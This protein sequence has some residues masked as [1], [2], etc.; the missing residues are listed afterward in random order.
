MTTGA[1]SNE[2]EWDVVVASREAQRRREKS[3]AKSSGRRSDIEG[4]R[5]VAIALVVIFHVWVGKVSG[6]VDIFLALS[7][8]FFFTG[9]M[10]WPAKVP[11]PERAWKTLRRLVPPMA[12]AVGTGLLLAVISLPESQLTQFYKQAITS[13]TFTQNWYLVDHGDSY[14]SASASV[15][16][17]QHL[18][19]MSVQAQIFLGSILVFTVVAWAANKANLHV[20]RVVIAAM[21]LLT[22]ASMVWAIYRHETNQAVA[23]YDTFARFWEISLGGLFGVALLKRQMPK[24]TREILGVIG[25]LL[26]VLSAWL[27]N[28]AEAYPG[29]LALVPVGSAMLMTLAGNGEE[30][31]VVTRVLDS[32]LPR[33]IGSIAYSLYLW[34]WILL[35]LFIQVK[36][37]NGHEVTAQ[38]V[39]F[40]EGSLII[41]VSIAIA[42]FSSRGIEPLRDGFVKNIPAIAV[43]CI[44]MVAAVSLF[45]TQVAVT[46]E[47]TQQAKEV[48]NYPGGLAVANGWTAG[49]QFPKKS[50]APAI[51]AAINDLPQTSINGCLAEEPVTEVRDCEFGDKTAD[52]FAIIAGGSHIEQWLPAIS[53]L[54]KQQHFKLKVAV[55]AGCPLGEG[56]MPLKGNRHDPYPECEQW[57]KNVR[58]W[59]L[60]EKPEVLITNSTRPIEFNQPDTVSPE[61]V[62]IFRTITKAG[63]PIIGIRDTPWHTNAKAAPIEIPECLSTPGNNESDCAVPRNQALAPVD[64]AIAAYAGMPGVTLVDMSN[65]ICRPD[66]CNPIEGNIIVYRDSHH[67]TKTYV[68]S[69]KEELARQ[70]LQSPAFKSLAGV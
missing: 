12:L 9:L 68:M 10:T 29:L 17:F 63:I 45:N 53:A 25:V 19:S 2:L 27:I 22:V 14:A 57:Q 43:T 35:I 55:K 54:A 16:P 24:V 4:M 34:H 23:Y 11:A 49:V 30:R 20:R 42:H 13:L 21:I 7:G 70:M 3:K 6:G 62:N 5:G 66:V 56:A 61:Y 15:S 41:L 37:A 58:D 59:I 50:P 28:G 40:T 44:A 52:K 33:Y 60:K 8:F 18:W 47:K 1:Y 46:Q 38:T 31:T 64:P 39:S 51:G 36:A 67:L 26:L 32:T 65:W 48:V 69:L